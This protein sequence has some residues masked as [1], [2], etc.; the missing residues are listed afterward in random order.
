MSPIYELVYQTG[1]YG[2]KTGA[3]WFDYSGEK[4]VPNP[5]VVTV[6][7]GYLKEK[8]VTPKAVAPQE[9]VDAMLARAINEAAYMIQEGICDRPRIWTWP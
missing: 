6:V 4:P 9:I 1:C 5:K 2:R 7:Q 8:R 3:G